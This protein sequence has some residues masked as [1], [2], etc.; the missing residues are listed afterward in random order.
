MKAKISGRT[1]EGEGRLMAYYMYVL[2][3]ETVAYLG[4]IFDRSCRPGTDL[5]VNVEVK[6][7]LK[8]ERIWRLLDHMSTIS[9]HHTVSFTGNS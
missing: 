3:A 8:G 2:Q 7:T 9:V 1:T 5:G 6:I 4:V